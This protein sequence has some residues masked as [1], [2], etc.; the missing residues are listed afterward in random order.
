MVREDDFPAVLSL[1]RAASTVANHRAL[2]EHQW[3]AL[4]RGG[5]HGYFGLVARS[6]E[7]EVIAY[8]QASADPD[9]GWD[10]LC[11]AHPGWASRSTK[12]EQVSLRVELLREILREAADRG[13]TT[14]RLW[15]PKAGELDDLVADGAGMVRDRD[16]VQMRR[17]LPTGE[18]A[19]AIPLRPFQEGEDE[20]AF[21]VVNNRA[22][23][24]HPEQG[25]WQVDTLV[26][27]ERQ[28]WFDAAGFL[29]SEVEGRLAGFC[30]T[31]LHT[32]GGD[33]I[34]PDVLEPLGEIYVIG[35][36]PDFAG[37]GLGRDLVL[38]GL[39]SLHERGAGTAM[40]YVAADND[41]ARR[42]YFAVGFGD[43]HVDRAY[44]KVLSSGAD[45]AREPVCGEG[46][47]L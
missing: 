40:L 26:E 4:E 18:P 41:A 2:G 25:S 8:G 45:S 29:L 36:D 23:S 33:P 27:R 31:K 39:A 9:S 37:H 1:L 6:D 30:W 24:G 42:L 19:G 38:A 20:Q 44:V 16:L 15:A 34:G 7:G 47:G 11:V 35:V 22:F 46:S 12:G 17:A 13:G 43:D 14:L 10:A 32:P 5:K 28:A 3:L 21:L